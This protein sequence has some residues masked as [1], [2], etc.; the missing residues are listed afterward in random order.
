M[1][2]PADGPELT[3]Y[4]RELI[5]DRVNVHYRGY[6]PDDDVPEPL[7]GPSERAGPSVPAADR[8]PSPES[9]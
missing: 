9:K 8:E 5:G 2:R 6:T 7:E 3:S 4:E 1:N